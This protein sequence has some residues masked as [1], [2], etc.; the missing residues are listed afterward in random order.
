MASM[1]SSSSSSYRE[2]LATVKAELLEARGAP[3]HRTE[4]FEALDRF[5]DDFRSFLVFPFFCQGPKPEDRTEVANSTS[6]RLSNEDIQIALRLSDDLNL[7]EV[8]SASL[9]TSTLEKGNFQDRGYLEIMR[10]SAGLWFIERDSL[11]A[12]LQLLLQAVALDK[13]FDSNFIAKIQLYIEKFLAAGLRSRLMSLIKELNEEG[14]TGNGDYG[15]EPYIKDSTGALVDRRAAIQKTRLS[16]CHCLYLSCLIAPPNPQELKDLYNLLKLCSGDDRFLHDATKLQITYTIMFSLTNALVL[17]AQGPEQKGFMLALDSSFCQEF[18]QLIMDVSE[19]TVNTEGF[20]GIVRLAWV[21]IRST[22]K[23]IREVNAIGSTVGDDEILRLCL[24][25][26]CDNDLFGFLN[27]R[28]FETIAFQ[29]D[30][31]ATAFKYTSSLCKLIMNLLSLPAGRQKIMELKYTSMGTHNPRI[32]HLK[33]TVPCDTGQA[34][35]QAVK[36]RAHPLVSFLHFAR[37]IFKRGPELVVNSNDLWSFVYFAGEGHTSYLSLVAFLD[38]LTALAECKEGAGKVYDMLQKSTIPSLGWQKLLTSLVVNDQQLQLRMDTTETFLPPFQEG[39][40]R[41]VEAYLKVLEKVIEKGDALERMQWFEDI[42]PLFKMLPR[43]NVSPFLKGALRNA[44][45]ACASVSSVMKEKVCSLLEQYDLPVLATPLP[46]DGSGHHSTKQ[47]YDLTYELNEVEARQQ[48]YPSTISYLKLRNLLA[49]HELDTKSG[50]Y[51]EIFQ[52]VRDQVFGLYSQRL[53]ANPVDKWELVVAALHHFEILLKNYQVTNEDARNK[54]SKH[55][56]SSMTTTLSAAKYTNVTPAMELIKDLKNGE[57]VYSNLMSILKLG[58]KSV[59]E[60]RESQLYGPVLEEAIS[61]SFQIFIHAFMKESLFVE[62][63]YPSHQPLHE[64]IFQSSHQ[65][66]TLLEYVRYD[67]CQLIQRYSVKVMELLSSRAPQ[68]VSVLQEAEAVLNLTEGYAACLEARFLEAHPPDNPDED[69]GYLILRL[70]L[71][72]LCEPSPNLTHL[73]LGFDINQLVERTTL[74]PNRDFSCLTVILH[75]LDKLA[76]PE[77]NTGLHELGFK[78]LY[79]LC[80]DSVTCGPMVDL[81]RNGKYDFLPKRTSLSSHDTGLERGNS[82]ISE[83]DL[84]SSEA[85]ELDLETCDFEP[86]AESAPET[87]SNSKPEVGFLNP[88]PLATRCTTKVND[89]PGEGSLA[90]LR[91][92]WIQRLFP[93]MLGGS[94]GPSQWKDKGKHIA[95]DY[96]NNERLLIENATR[97]AEDSGPSPQLLGGGQDPGKESPHCDLRPVKREEVSATDI[98]L[99]CTNS[100]QLPPDML[101]GEGLSPGREAYGAV[102]GLAGEIRVKSAMDTPHSSENSPELAGLGHQEASVDH[103]AN[104]T[105]FSNGLTCNRSPFAYPRQQDL[106]ARDVGYSQIRDI[107]CTP[108]SIME[109]EEKK[110]N[111]FLTP[112][113]KPPSEVDTRSMQVEHHPVQR[114]PLS[115]R[116]FSRLS[117]QQQQQNRYD[118]NSLDTSNRIVYQAESPSLRSK[119]SGFQLGGTRNIS[120]AECL[121]AGRASGDKGFRFDNLKKG[122]NIEHRARYG[123]DTEKNVVSLG[124]SPLPPLSLFAPFKHNKERRSIESQ[125]RN[126][127]AAGLSEDSLLTPLFPSC[128]YKSDPNDNLGGAGVSEEKFDSAMFSQYK[129]SSSIYQSSGLRGLETPLTL[130]PI[131][132][133]FKTLEEHNRPLKS[134][135]KTKIWPLEKNGEDAVG[136]DTDMDLDA[137]PEP[138]SQQAD[139]RGQ[140]GAMNVHGSTLKDGCHTVNTTA[141]ELSRKRPSLHED[142]TDDKDLS[143]SQSHDEQLSVSQGMRDLFQFDQDLQQQRLIPEAGPVRELRPCINMVSEVSSGSSPIPCGA[144]S[145]QLDGSKIEAASRS[146]FRGGNMISASVKSTEMDQVI[147]DKDTPGGAANFNALGQSS[148]VLLSR[149]KHSMPGMDGHGLRQESISGQAENV[150][151]SVNAQ[152]DNSGRSSRKRSHDARASE[153]QFALQNPETISLVEPLN[154]SFAGNE[155]R[156]APHSQSWLQRWMPSPKPSTTVF[157]APQP[158]GS[159]PPGQLSSHAKNRKLVQ[160]SITPGEQLVGA[161]L[162]GQE[163]QRTSQIQKTGLWAGSS[164]GNHHRR[165]NPLFPGFYPVPSAAAMALVGAASRRAVPLPP[166]R[167]GT[168]IAVWPAI[169]GTQLRRTESGSSGSLPPQAEVE[170]VVEEG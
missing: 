7:N 13:E 75:A 168:R 35:N 88:E 124:S 48:E 81:L 98:V 146:G 120:D 150:K 1:S 160:D 89:G 93:G 23:Q 16:L 91:S 26:A 59:L 30:E 158:C 19:F 2:L 58:V 130:T 31:R 54:S 95:S 40:A 62:A 39:D 161:D 76:R 109:Q 165:S 64:I 79:E 169:T 137:L 139:H 86:A 92:S 4:L 63:W 118:L 80:V 114:H 108:P 170:V 11:I 6:N 143:T 116:N 20:T 60:Q 29:N 32:N 52:F 18:Q 15:L 121:P 154:Q 83:T 72:N 141:I 42:E 9:V 129:P 155:R 55:S 50:R 74:Q 125:G 85:H 66:V 117:Q 115:R 164:S 131:F 94:V 22:S 147:P 167:V 24:N 97:L 36:L 53:Y 126:K 134:L 90:A 25:R 99:P 123:V 46:T 128:G 145:H 33:D 21:L 105:R 122:E 78:L 47:F 96:E 119:N 101:C 28:V 51:I 110:M 106:H 84:C 127:M 44:I 142:R 148:E 12:S 10:I 162:D 61:L 100:S 71:V 107:D 113:H 56:L 45:A 87:P 38:M 69:I 136:K 112:S 77:V 151:L 102:R 132:A 5:L 111:A 27:T 14:S 138:E 144:V 166:Q 135:I 156:T 65:V 157:K 41:V 57:V 49:V 34:Q 159:V 133:P 17:G 73:L 68:L 8:Y 70:L 103:A 3:Q 67:K 140:S 153:S 149:Q 163:Q 43:E 37:E 152:E 82:S 104:S